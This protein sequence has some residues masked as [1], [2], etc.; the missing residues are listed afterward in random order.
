MKAL[1]LEPDEEITSVV[2]RLKEIDDEEVA[3]VVPKRAG[4][5]QSIVNLKL[6]RYQAEQMKKRIS[7]VTT[8][9]TG[10][11]L[12]SAVGLTVHQKLPDGK[13]AQ[14]AKPTESAVK[15]P[16]EEIPIKY[17]RQPPKTKEEQDEE[18]INFKKGAGPEMATKSID[19]VADSKPMDEPEPVKETKI[20]VKSDDEPKKSSGRKLPKVAFPKV[21]LPKLRKDKPSAKSQKLEKVPGAKKVKKFS[22]KIAAA[23]VL[24]LLLAGGATAAVVLPKA[25]VTVS[26]KTTP[27]NASV[28]LTFSTR[29]PSVDTD[30]NIIPS[31]TIEVTKEGSR[32]VSATGKSEGGEKASGEITVTNTLPRNQSLVT[33]TRFQSP[34]GKIYRAQSGIVVPAGGQTTVKVTADTGGTAGNLTA[35]T[36]LTI[37][38]LKGSDAVTGQADKA[39][40]GGTD[41]ATTTIS[42]D[43]VEHAKQEL[44]N[45]IALEGAAEAKSKLAVGYTLNPKIAAVTVL[46]SSSDPAAGATATTFTITGRVRITYFTYQEKELNQVLDPDLKAQVPAGTDLTDTAKETFA[47]T[48]SSRDQLTGNMKIDTSASTSVSKDTVKDEIKGKTPEE[49][50]KALAAS[51]QAN[52]IQIKLFPFWVMHVPKNSKKI[53]VEFKTGPGILPV[54][55]P[56]ATPSATSGQPQI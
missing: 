36:K 42:A 1:Y 3:I 8:D 32:K 15:E 6:L 13:A 27:V 23:I 10:R 22:W 33:N 29:A 17:R 2:D 50:R 25:T 28:P 43:D 16:T 53:V 26:P 37:P 39:L 44:A 21:K 49:A 54:A 5:L 48:Q 41:S 56:S 19:E 12:A 20:P 18:K 31:K 4:I 47:V 35:G 46:A 30:G 34:D 55:S 24:V 14:A 38:G 11:N 52:N 7:L 45:Q 9:K 51:G 40:T